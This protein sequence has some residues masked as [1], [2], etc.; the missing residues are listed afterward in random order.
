MRWVFSR[1]ERV[2]RSA[3]TGNKGSR[4]LGNSALLRQRHWTSTSSDDTTAA[5]GHHAQKALMA[6]QHDKRVVRA[7]PQL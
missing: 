5:R 2:T 1:A 3:S 7:M 4:N 6:T